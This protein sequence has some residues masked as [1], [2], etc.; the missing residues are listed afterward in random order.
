MTKFIF[1]AKQKRGNEVKT[2]KGLV[3]STNEKL[4]AKILRKRNL[5]PINI[6]AT[7]ESF[8]KQIIIKFFRKITLADLAN[9]TRN[10]STMITA[11]LPLTDALTIL[12]EQSS[13]KLALVIEDVSTSI[14]GGASL[15]DALER[16]PKVFSKVYVALVRAG[17]SA[18]VLD[19]VL[20]RL[21]DNLEKSREFQGKVKG[22]MIYPAIIIVGMVGVAFV[23]MIFVIPKLT[24]LYTEF[25]TDLPAPTK[26]LIT[27]SN[28]LVSNLLLVIASI[29]SFFYLLKIFQKTNAG[30][31]KI[32][33][34][35]LN[36]PLLGSLQKQMILAEISRT[37]GLLV[38]SGIQIVEALNIV[39]GASSNLVY[40]EGVKKAAK[41]VEKGFPLSQALA[42]TGD[43]PMILPQLVAVGEETGK[44]DEVLEKTSHFFE[45]E[46]DQTLKGLTSAIEPLI[47]IVLGLGVGFLII[48]IILPIYNLTS[49]F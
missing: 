33:S 16:H 19:N 22:A 7:K 34:F 2:I 5:I 41:K 43:F 29:I 28:F 12:K 47:M 17:E 3:E 20:K 9:F 48:A 46:S 15:S 24:G 32:D 45:T 39:S 25:G 6:E 36:F 44:I 13:S 8:F 49:Q 42:E 21:A 1:T 40:I 35:K 30:K 27:I 31:K 10:L 26:I 23:M 37:L 4:A 18:G 14:E 38:S 11:G